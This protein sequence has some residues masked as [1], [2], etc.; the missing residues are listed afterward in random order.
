MLIYRS[1]RLV[2]NG[3]VVTSKRY[4][5]SGSSST[6]Y[7]PSSSALPV[8]PSKKMTTVCS[9][10]NTRCNASSFEL[11]PNNKRPFRVKK[12]L[13]EEYRSTVSN[14]KKCM[15]SVSMQAT[16]KTGHDEL[17]IFTLVADICLRLTTLLRLELLFL[18]C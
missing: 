13:L 16:H 8:R 4:T 6:T 1:V 10:R 5:S 2:W 3:H 11:M 7:L 9:I 14:I 15:T 18:Q 17:N 12:K